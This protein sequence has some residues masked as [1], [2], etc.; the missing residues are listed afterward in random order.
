MEGNSAELRQVTHHKM[1][2]M[3]EKASDM[4]RDIRRKTYCMKAEV[5][6]VKI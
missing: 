4:A 2:D 1:A 3:E 5:K 6:K